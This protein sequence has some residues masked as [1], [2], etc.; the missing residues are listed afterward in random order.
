MSRLI[1]Y[2][3]IHGCLDELITLRTK[4]AIQ[5]EDIEVCTGDVITKGA[6][7]ISILKYLRKNGIQSVLG[8]HEEIILRYIKHTLSKDTQ[9]PMKLDRDQKNILKNLSYKDIAFLASFPYFIQVDNYI[10]VHG[11]LENSMD[12][13][14]LTKRDKEKMIRLRYLDTNENFI[15]YGNENEESVFWSDIYDGCN[16]FVLFGHNKFKEPKISEHAIGL[17][18]GCVY[19]NR[20]TAIVIENNEKRFESVAFG[21]RCIKQ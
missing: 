14:N 6:N 19:G 1:V 5:K 12:L 15:P 20:L 3:D 9:N 17:D 8:N 18:T 16:G 21:E 2:G 13:A 4:I 7:S 11:G 10:I